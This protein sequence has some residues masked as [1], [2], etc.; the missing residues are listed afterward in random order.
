MSDTKTHKHPDAPMP[1][2]SCCPHCSKEIPDPRL[3]IAAARK[4]DAELI[5]IL[6]DALNKCPGHT[7]ADTKAKR[8]AL[9]LASSKG[10]TPTI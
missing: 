2:V 8:A 5:Q 3:A 4:S 9:S 6:V 10:Y 7:E 1:A